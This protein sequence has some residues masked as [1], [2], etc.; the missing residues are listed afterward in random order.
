MALPNI[1][2][3]SIINGLERLESEKGENKTEDIIS[4]YIEAFQSRDN[5]EI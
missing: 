5:L 1:S 2:E 4:Y 3:S